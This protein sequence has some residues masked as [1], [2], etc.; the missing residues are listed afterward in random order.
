MNIVLLLITTSFYASIVAAAADEEFSSAVLTAIP[1]YLRVHITDQEPSKNVSYQIMT[2]ITS[3]AQQVVTCVV[4]GPNLEKR[5]PADTASQ[6]LRWINLYWSFRLLN[7]DAVQPF[8]FWP[9]NAVDL[10]KAGCKFDELRPGKPSLM[11]DPSIIVA[12]FTLSERGL[13]YAGVTRNLTQKDLGRGIKLFAFPD[14]SVLIDRNAYRKL[15]FRLKP[16]L[17]S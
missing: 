12:L 11:A 16:W 17:L 4:A 8:G 6:L 5:Y 1:H 2:G 14:V 10:A 3:T 7:T 9:P 13:D 15:L